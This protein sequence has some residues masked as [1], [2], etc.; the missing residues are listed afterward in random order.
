[1]IH[2]STLS[3]TELLR[4]LSTEERRAYWLGRGIGH[5]RLRMRG[6]A[7]VYR[8]WKGDHLPRYAGG[9]YRWRK[10]KPGRRIP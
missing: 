10:A 1:M 8:Y 7:E 3:V 9:G 6:Y 4:Y 2:C 5:F